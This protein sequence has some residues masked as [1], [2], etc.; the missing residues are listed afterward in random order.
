M[1]QV[2]VF[3]FSNLATDPRVDRQIGFLRTRHKIV[4]AG[5]V[6]PTQ[7]VDDFVELSIPKRTF[8]SSAFGVARLLTRRYDRLYWTHPAYIAALERLRNVRV[9]V[10]VAND[11]NSLPIALRL[12]RP[13]VFDAHEYAPGQFADR[14]WW[15]LMIAP[16]MRWLCRNYIPQAASMTTIGEAI[17][18]AYERDTGVRATVVTNAPPHVELE[19]TQVHE[20]I[21]ILHHGGAQLGRGLEEMVRVGQLLDERFTLDFVLVEASP[22]YRE[23]LIRQAK[24]NP[25]IRFPEPWPMHSL[26]RQA[27]DYDIGMFLL[28]PI[29]FQRR[30]ALPNKFFEFVQA[31]LAVAVG[32]SPE[33]ASIVH[34]YG[35]G[36]V[37][38]DFSA[39]T[40]AAAINRLTGSEIASFKEASHRA[41]NE[42]SAES[43]GEI[44]LRLV[45]EAL[46]DRPRVAGT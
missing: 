45:G 12:G 13:V 2:L 33:M 30:F 21:R 23:K 35:C 5:L 19:P 20:P 15:R 28:P 27:N 9:D 43:N 32:P 18:D 7:P 37:A 26:V 8:L 25:R 39:E 29:S 3:S 42:L 22:G 44:I 36:I 17:A 10:V 4:A 11:L 14:A 34:R 6:P 1:A 46:S 24:G 40:L 41:A 16:Y 38:D 31:R